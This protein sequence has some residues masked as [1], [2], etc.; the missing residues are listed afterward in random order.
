MLDIDT[1]DK[2]EQRKFGLVMG[3]AIALLGLLRYALHG[4]EHF[5]LYFFIVAAVFAAF[6]L[7]FPKALQPVFV[8]WIKFALVLNW[9]MTRV[10][11]TITF[12]LMMAPVRVILQLFS[13][14]PLKRAFKDAKETYWE[15]AEEQPKEFER[16]RQQF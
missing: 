3:V 6:G 16:Y 9:I 11:L 14:D 7:V 12:Y 5:P 15:D 8:V 4:F 10:F 2:K 1:S 13:D